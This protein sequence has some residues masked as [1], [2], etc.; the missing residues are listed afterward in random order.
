MNQQTIVLTLIDFVC[1]FGLEIFILNEF[2]SD[3]DSKNN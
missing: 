2:E 1:V 3:F